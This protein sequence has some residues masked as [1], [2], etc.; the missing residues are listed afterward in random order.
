MPRHSYSRPAETMRNRQTLCVKCPSD[1]PGD[2]DIPTFGWFHLIAAP[3]GSCRYYVIPQPHRPLQNH[4]QRML[5]PLEL[6]HAHEEDIR[7][8]PTPGPITR[9]NLAAPTIPTTH[10]PGEIP[11]PQ[12]CQEIPFGTER[13]TGRLLTHPPPTCPPYSRH[14]A[15]RTTAGGNTKLS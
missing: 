13:S 14:A 7:E 10:N 1:T 12:L 8:F 11:H 9:S 4:L 2:P 3:G 5:L 15:L 6:T